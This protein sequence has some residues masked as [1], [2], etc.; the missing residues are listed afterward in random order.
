[1]RY[2][3]ILLLGICLISCKEEKKNLLP[4]PTE[5]KMDMEDGELKD[6]KKEF[7]KLIHQAEEGVN[8]ETIEANTAYAKYKAKGKTSLNYRGGEEIILDGVLR[9]EWIE[10]GSLNQAGSVFKPQYDPIQDKIY[11]V[12]AE[13]NIWK[14]G[15]NGLSWEV[16]NDDLRF[17]NQF[18]LLTTN[19]ENNPRLIS[20][21]NG[22]PVYSDDDGITWEISEGMDEYSNNFR[23]PFMLSNG[24]IYVLNKKSYWDNFEIFK[25]TDNGLTYESVK[26][27]NTSDHRNLSL[28]N[29]NKSDEL[30]VLEQISSTESHVHQWSDA[31]EVFEQVTT[32]SPISSGQAGQTNL[33]GHIDSNGNIILYSFDNN[34]AFYKSLDLGVSWEQL[35]TLPITPWRVGLFISKSNPDIMIIG[36]VDAYRSLD[37]GNTWQLINAWWEYYDDVP[38]KLHADMMYFEEFY[39]ASNDPFIIISHHG[40]ISKSYDGTQTNTNFSLIGLNVSQYYSVKSYPLD[41]DFIFA[42]SQDQGLQR[43]KV[44]GINPVNFDQVISGDYGHNTFTDNGQRFWTVYPGGAVSY[45]HQPLT[46][47]GPTF[48]YEVNSNDESV[49]IPPMM[50]HPDPT[51][52]EIY[53]AGGND[54]GGPGAHI[55]HLEVQGNQILSNNLPFDFSVSG[56]QIS[57]MA[58]NPFDHDIWYVTT[59]NGK[60]YRST[61]GAQSFEGETFNVPGGHYLYGSCILPSKVDENTIYISGS[62]YSNAGVL[63]STDGG[64]GFATM[65]NGLPPTTIFCLAANEDESLIFAAT[66][67]GPYVYISEEEEWFDLSGMAGPNVRY[68]SVEFLEDKQ[69]A[70]F[71][72]YGR[73]IWDFAIAQPSLIEDVIKDESFK[74]FPNP[75]DNFVNI[76]FDENISLPARLN[77]RDMQ[78]KL[79][80]EQE[81]FN[82]SQEIN[83]ST[84]S[85]GNY[86][87]SISDKNVFLNQ[88]LV[89]L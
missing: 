17:S 13:G 8:W 57:A 15:L 50:A 81:I 37:G 28:C 89:K 59:A 26:T 7:F 43:G 33:D 40:G 70:R 54:N 82:R 19:E 60:F 36:G 48:G 73:G 31:T 12:S 53:V 61:D 16:I 49:W 47:G 9:G 35:S 87:I 58:V 51:K 23:D 30:F 44:S 69:V 5:V 45:Y 72:T 1:M 88:K 76:E 10:R 29:I 41:N 66:E 52:N 56:S 2:Y 27:F 34:N 32:N 80:L 42:G 62:G 77:I 71:G 63:K 85:S 67:A 6:V 84:L 3:L 83:I 11:L 38:N 14:G 39:D 86:I 18:F 75:V 20:A 4:L 24:D 78:G 46:Q 64:N 21:L 65:I 25:S 79:I 55:I 22:E 68:W 74:I